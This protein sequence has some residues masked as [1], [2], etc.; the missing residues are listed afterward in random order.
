M[1]EIQDTLAL[2]VERRWRARH[3]V[4]GASLHVRAAATIRS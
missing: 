2:R 4:N 3:T 1:K